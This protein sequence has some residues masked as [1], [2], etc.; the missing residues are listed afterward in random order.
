MKSTEKYPIGSILSRDLSGAAGIIYNHVGIYVGRGFVVHFNGEGFGCSDAKIRK[1]KLAAFADGHEVHVYAAPENAEH[2]EAVKREAEGYW[3]NRGNE[4]NG[5]YSFIFKN[6][7][8]FCCACFNVGN[9]KKAPTSQRG[10][11]IKAA[12]VGAAAVLHELA[13][14][15]PLI[16][17]GMTMTTTRVWEVTHGPGEIVWQPHECPSRSI[18]SILSTAAAPWLSVA[19][20]AISSGVSIYNAFQLA[21]QEKILTRISHK[22]GIID[23]KLNCV[24]GKLDKIRALTEAAFTTI[25]KIKNLKLL[26]MFFDNG[27]ILFEERIRE[28][29]VSREAIL[30]LMNDTETAWREIVCTARPTE[31]PIPDN[32]IVRACPVFSFL[33]TL[34]F[35][36]VEAHNQ[37][38]DYDPTVTRRY[39]SI[40]DPEPCYLNET[41]DAE[42]VKDQIDALQSVQRIYKKTTLDK[43]P[44]LKWLSAFLWEAKMACF[45]L[46]TSSVLESQPKDKPRKLMIPMLDPETENA[47]KNSSKSGKSASE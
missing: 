1:D 27:R 20:S 47:I 23:K 8:D 38:N 30:S 21:K 4:F 35:Y 11:T 39:I 7:E 16:K 18:G 24:L 13:A 6:C 9:W 25:I 46:S 26:E 2:G 17:E 12:V 41:S 22:L 14:K 43:Q 34:N 5:R 28:N 40:E 15:K 3:R 36:L 45:T 19:F 37:F 10:K 42:K 29:S 44:R 31:A 32:M 33:R